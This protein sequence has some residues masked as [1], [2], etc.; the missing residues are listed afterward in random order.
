MLLSGLILKFPPIFFVKKKKNAELT[1]P[2]HICSTQHQQCRI[3]HNRLQEN[4]GII[5]LRFHSS[6]SHSSCWLSGLQLPPRTGFSTHLTSAYWQ[7]RISRNTTLP[8]KK[9]QQRSL[10]AQSLCESLRVLMGARKAR[11][12]NSGSQIAS[13]VTEQRLGPDK[14]NKYTEVQKP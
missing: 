5:R 13:T 12:Q 14:S 1:H 11:S 9:K 7:H 8:Q 2:Q 6:L 4:T 10:P 3:L